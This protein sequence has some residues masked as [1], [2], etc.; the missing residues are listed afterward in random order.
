MKIVFLV[1]NYMPHQLVSIQSVIKYYSAEVHAFNYKDE[2][3]IPKG[4]ENLHTYQ[5]KAF[6]RNQFLNKIIDTKPEM[7]VVAGW[8]VKDFV[9]VSKKVRN[10]LNIPVVSYSDTQWRGTWKQKVN[11]FISPWHI[12]KAYSHL[13]VAGMYQFEY[14]RKLGFAK[15]QI[16]YNSLSCDVE[17]FRQ[18]S[19]EH[20]QNNYPKN[21]LFI[22]RFVPVKGLDLLIEAWQKIEDKKGWTITL[23]GDGPLKEKF[24]NIEGINIKDFMPQDLLIKEIE[25]AGCFVLPSVYEPWALVIHEAA[26]SG[27]P[28][29]ATENCGAAPHF[30]ISDWNGFQ[31]KPQVNSIKIALQ[32]IMDLDI[33]CLMRFSENSRKLAESITPE[34]GAAQLMSILKSSKLL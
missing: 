22:G 9:W 2:H 13:W 26:A 27:L 21:F 12:K 8:A 34:L 33:T 10:K 3:T 29:I 25:I 31:V 32:D 1:I 7:M 19:L 30:V 16:I 18:T 24:R 5:L 20:K 15:N 23:I 4:I 11:S 14:A 6:N 28:I 17:L